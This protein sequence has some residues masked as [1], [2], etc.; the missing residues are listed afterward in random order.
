MRMT[1]FIGLNKEAQEFLNKHAEKDIFQTVKNGVVVKE[2]VEP[3]KV[4]GKFST[5]G[6]FDENI[7]LGGFVLTD[8]RTIHEQ[9]QHVE[10]SSGPMIFTQLVDDNNNPIVSW[11]DEE[12]R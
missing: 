2:W 11:P 1:Q 7:Q 5:E 12:M 10:W 3:R 8:G 6:M 4:K 9:E